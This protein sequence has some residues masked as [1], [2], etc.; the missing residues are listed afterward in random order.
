MFGNKSNVTTITSVVPQGT[1]EEQLDGLRKYGRPSL[2]Y[3]GDGWYCT[4]KMH[5]AAAGTSF[6][7]KSDFGSKTSHPSPSDAVRQCY[8]R[9]AA[10]LALYKE[11]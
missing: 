2:N 9:I 8:E 1:L 5:V 4:V 7:V 11:K 10:T 3:D 6:D